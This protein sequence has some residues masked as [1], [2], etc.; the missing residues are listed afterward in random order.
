VRDGQDVIGHQ[1]LGL[2]EPPGK[3]EGGKE[4]GRV[5]G[6]VI[7]HRREAE[8]QGGSGERVEQDQRVGRKG[9]EEGKEGKGEREGRKEATIRLSSKIPLGGEIQD[10]SL[11][12]N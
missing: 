12:R 4:G 7:S 6:E 10:L 11:E 8:V 5:R 9:R 1:V 3:G 2:V